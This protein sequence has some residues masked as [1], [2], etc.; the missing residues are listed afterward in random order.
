MYKVLKKALI[1][2][3]TVFLMMTSMSWDGIRVIA[4]ENDNGIE[5][6]DDTPDAIIEV[7]PGDTENDDGNQEVEVIEVNEGTQSEQNEVVTPVQSGE[8]SETG[9]NKAPVT[10]VN[11]QPGEVVENKDPDNQ[12]PVVEVKA[13]IGGDPVK[14]G[15]EE[16]ITVTF[17]PTTDPNEPLAPITIEVNTGETIGN[18]LP[19][20]DEIPD[21]KSVV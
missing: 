15:E 7:D 16:T 20:I 17:N 12:E 2:F 11:E 8:N 13:P 1:V 10:E 14:A 19:T 18:K 4:E 9:E 5:L 21:R 3:V 6:I